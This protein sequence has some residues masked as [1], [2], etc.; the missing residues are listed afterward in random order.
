MSRSDWGY[1]RRIKLSKPCSAYLEL[2][3][4]WAVD[5]A[6]K[7]SQQLTLY[8]GHLCWPSPSVTESCIVDF[9]QYEDLVAFGDAGTL[10]ASLPRSRSRGLSGATNRRTYGELDEQS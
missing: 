1:Q 4:V 3:R 10:R 9:R 2:S 8:I 6:I 7:F 5:D